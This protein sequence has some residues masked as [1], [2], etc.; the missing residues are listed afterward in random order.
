MGAKWYLGT[1]AQNDVVIST[2]VHLVRNLREFP[3]P[4]MLTLQDKL[5]VNSIINEAASFTDYNFNYLEMKMLSQ[6]EVVS[7]AERHLISPEFA[8]SRDGRALLITDDEAVSVMLN[9]EDHIRFQVMYAAFSLDE[10]Y[11]TANEIDNALSKKL[12]F[13][14]DERIGYLT[15][16]PTI[17]GTGMKASVVLHLPGLAGLMQIPKL[18]STV[19]KLGLT[20]R[21]SYGEGAAAKGD[22]F[23]L[24]NSITLGISEKAA[25]ENLKSIAL[26][27]AAQERSAR[28]EILKSNAT[29]D[30]IFRAYGTL[31]YARLIDTDELM[32]LMSLVR[33]GAV[34]G[35]INIDTAKIEGM[36]INM[37]PATISLSV[38]RPLD[39]NGRDMLRAKRVR[40]LLE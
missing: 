31:K 11:R 6:Y 17:I 16:D 24:S 26:Q 5:K 22:L 30:K 40:E 29:E 8:S 15:Q 35:L 25:I 14:F 36:M 38:D 12:N 20:L 28:E 3:F 10:A 32:E 23:R 37:Q 1:G 4:Q 27:I 21:G 2:S 39:R 13:A 18:I 34:K 9:E 7:L 33:L 19:Q